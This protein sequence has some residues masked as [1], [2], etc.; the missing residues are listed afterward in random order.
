MSGTKKRKAQAPPMTRSQQM[1]RIGSR[2]TKPEITLRK[3][4]WADGFRYRVHSALPGR[5]DIAISKT[6]LAIFVDGCFWHGC[7]DHYRP[8]STNS[9]YWRQKRSRNE[10]RDRRVDREL[11]RTG[12][13]VVRI[14]EHEVK[15]DLDRVI[16]RIQEAHLDAV[17]AR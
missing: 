6:R 8:P 15:T 13:T 7:P 4:L 10:D 2:D 14:W 9:S 16:S 3:R 17:A 11:H 12:W 5:P 1:A